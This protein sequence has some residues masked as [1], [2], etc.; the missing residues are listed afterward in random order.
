MPLWNESGEAALATADVF[1]RF[2]RLDAAEKSLKTASMDLSGDQKALV[3][4]KLA[5]VLVLQ[6]KFKSAIECLRNA[7]AEA[8]TI[9]EPALCLAILLCD[10]SQYSDAKRAFSS[11]VGGDVSSR[12]YRACVD[13]RISKMLLK[14][15]EEYAES[16]RPDDAIRFVR[17]AESI[18]AT[19][20]DHGRQ[21]IRLLAKNRRFADLKKFVNSEQGQQIPD[22]ER[23][24]FESIAVS[25][26][27]GAKIGR[28]RIEALTY[29]GKN[30]KNSIFRR[31]ASLWT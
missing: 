25:E 27:E 10:L 11:A 26:I 2:G 5:H 18:P 9:S 31:I 13:Q 16:D 21:L 14:I 15:A 1:I 4:T 3:G 19:N 28:L 23:A 30:T 8:K 20:I 12:E 29:S 22:I 17:M 6:G 7:A 24:V